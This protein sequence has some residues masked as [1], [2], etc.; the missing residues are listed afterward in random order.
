MRKLAVFVEGYTELI[1]IEK[2]IK[3]IAGAH[4]V[5]FQKMKIRGGNTV[6]R[7]S[8]QINA[9]NPQTGQPF[10][11]LIVD[12]GN[13][14]LVKTRILEEHENLTRSGY[15][16]IIGMRDVRPNFTYAE[17]PK[18]EMGLRTRVKTSLIPVVFVLSVM[19]IEAWFL[20]EFT[21]FPKID[22]T[23][24][25]PSIRANLGFDPEHDDLTSRPTPT[26]DLNNCYQ[27]GGKSYEKKNAADTVAVLDYSF[28]YFD[29]QKRIM[30]LKRLVDAVDEFLV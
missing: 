7:T 5:F 18:L 25:V 27:L 29:L 28:L 11:I 1:F 21:H 4:N 26:V 9:A 13:D 10:F 12:C 14:S 3:E 17:I 19:E 15:T 2:F 20:S 16:K 8:T 23:I 30:H 6:S 24:T 22:P